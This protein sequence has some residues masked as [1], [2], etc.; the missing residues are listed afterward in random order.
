MCSVLLLRGINKLHSA[1]NMLVCVCMLVCVYMLVCVCMLVCV[2][3]YACVLCDGSNMM[4]TFSS[5]SDFQVNIIQSFVTR[6]ELS[7]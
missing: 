4:G 6:R 7:G 5:A 2:P 3:V 1:A